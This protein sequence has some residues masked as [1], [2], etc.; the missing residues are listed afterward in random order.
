MPLTTSENRI[1]PNFHADRDMTRPSKLGIWILAS[2]PKTLWAAVAPVMVGTAMAFESGHGALLPAF[3]ALFGAIAI[4]VGT[5][6]AND[7]FDCK[8]GADTQ[9]R[10]GP[11]RVTQAGLVRPEAMKI[12]IVT[13]FLLAS[14]AGG[15]LIYCAGW[16][17]A[18]IGVLSIISGILYTAGPYPLGYVG[19]GDIFVLI[20]FGPV[21]VGGTYYVQTLSLEPAVLLAGLG[22]GFFSVAILAV[23]NLRDID[24]DSKTGKRTLAVRFGRRFAQREYLI[25]ILLASFIPAILVMESRQH[26]WSLL[27]IAVPLIGL[28]AIKTVFVCSDGPTLNNVLATTGKLL[29]LFSVIFSVGWLF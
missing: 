29:L 26:L 25:S 17:I 20:F 15:Y 12:G 28:N 3:A 23:N 19:L 10:L 22:P 11:T 24:S 4:Q 18:V 5:N 21:A 14:A 6:L 9:D 8:K 7:Y 27:A 2:R 13:A 16:P 1:F